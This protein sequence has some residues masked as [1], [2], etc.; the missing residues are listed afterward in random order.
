[1]SQ[2][3][4]PPT[5]VTPARTQP[6]ARVWLFSA[7]LFASAALLF[8]VQPIV[9]KRLVPLLGGSPNVWNTCMLFFQA[10]LLGGY[11]YAHLSSSWLTTRTQAFLHVV[12]LLA[13]ALTLPIEL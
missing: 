11:G 6:A 2:L 3:L 5:E 1:M 12:L 9:A 4:Q 10:A 13:A 7:A 8:C